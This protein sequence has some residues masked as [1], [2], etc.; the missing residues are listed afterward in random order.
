MGKLQEGCTFCKDPFAGRTPIEAGRLDLAIM[1][2]PLPIHWVLLPH[3][4]GM[5]S[6]TPPGKHLIFTTV[7]HHVGNE[8]IL[9]EKVREQLLVVAHQICV[10]HLGKNF[11]LVLN[12][13]IAA[14]SFTHFHAHCIAPG[15]GERLPSLVKNIQAELDKAA[16]EGLITKE[17][18]NALKERLLQK[19]R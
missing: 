5:N 12:Q 14:S 8:S 7:S 4:P 10:K 1:G 2:Q 15:P 16:A 3:L 9:D 11:R 17:A 13:G 6:V 19:A 18:A